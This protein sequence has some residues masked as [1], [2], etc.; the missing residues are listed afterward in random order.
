MIK[1]KVTLSDGRVVDAPDGIGEHTGKDLEYAKS[2]D[3]KI[4]VPSRLVMELI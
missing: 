3:K 1:T 2:K 4:I